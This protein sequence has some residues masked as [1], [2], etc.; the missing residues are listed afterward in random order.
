MEFFG[1][2]FGT[3]K[4]GSSPEEKKP[5][6]KKAPNPSRRYFLK[7]GVGAVGAAAL[8]KTALGKTFQQEKEK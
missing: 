8:E 6:T 7:F 5:A 2:F 4:E 1:K 3:N